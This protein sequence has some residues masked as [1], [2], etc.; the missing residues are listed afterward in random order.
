[1]RDLKTPSGKVWHKHEVVIRRGDSIGTASEPEMSIMR[2]QKESWS[3][4]KPTALEILTECLSDPTKLTRVSTLIG[5]EANFLT[6]A[7]NEISSL[8]QEKDLAPTELSN[9]IIIYDQLVSGFAKLFVFGCFH[10]SSSFRSI[11][12][13]ALT[14][15]GQLERS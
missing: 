13:R 7:L 12:P 5:S 14:D 9:R 15:I 3:K 8:K 6:R 10:G 11:W 4:A 1:V 2:T